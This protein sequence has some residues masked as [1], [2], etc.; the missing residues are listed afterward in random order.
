MEDPMY[1]VKKSLFIF[2]IATLVCSNAVNA[3]HTTFRKFFPKA[4]TGIHWY[5][6]ASPLFDQAIRLYNNKK[7]EFPSSFEITNERTKQFITEQLTAV[8]VPDAS[9]V[10]AYSVPL[11]KEGMIGNDGNAVIMGSSIESLIT[12]GEDCKLSELLMMKSDIEQILTLGNAILKIESDPDQKKEMQQKQEEAEEILRVINKQ[13]NHYKFGLQQQGSQIR[14]RRADKMIVLNAV[15]P[16][17]THWSIK[18]LRQ[19]GVTARVLNP[20]QPATSMLKHALRIPSGIGKYF[21]SKNGIFVVERQLELRADDAVTDDIDVLKAGAEFFRQ[22][23]QEQKEIIEKQLQIKIPTNDPFYKF[24]EFLMD[25][26][27]PSKLVR[28]ERLAERARTLYLK[29]FDAP[30]AFSN[31][32]QNSQANSN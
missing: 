22:R 3:M 21:I 26:A 28:A 16:F 19:L 24:N 4:C 20:A 15:A 2:I 32:D 27:H 31:V 18:G 11:V 6:A 9:K 10:K 8:K 17:I 7:R 14:D 25:P 29:K 30:I 23:D 1:F 5:L 13:I 12:T